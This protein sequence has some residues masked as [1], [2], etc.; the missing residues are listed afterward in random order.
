[1]DARGPCVARD[2]LGTGERQGAHWCP[3]F[4]SRCAPYAARAYDRAIAFRFGGV[5][6]GHG[7]RG[8]RREVGR[9]QN[10]ACH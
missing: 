10:Q 5:C 7:L 6:E 8:L 4:G 9:C 3:C 1:M 2:P